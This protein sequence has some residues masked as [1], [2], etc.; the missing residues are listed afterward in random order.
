MNTHGRAKIQF[1]AFLTSA[2]CGSEWRASNANS[3]NPLP[4]CPL[5]ESDP[6]AN[7]VNPRACLYA[8]KKSL[9]LPVIE[10]CFPAPPN[11][12]TILTEL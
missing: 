6:C 1:H 12:V 10:H 2:L 3:F 4:H 9:P 7:G 8:V 5:E 11:T